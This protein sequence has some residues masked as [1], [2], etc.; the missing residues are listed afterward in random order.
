MMKNI[1]RLIPFLIIIFTIHVSVYAQNQKEVKRILF[2]GNSYT[3]VLNTPQLVSIISEDTDTKLLTK[4]ST[5]GGAFL[6][7]HWQ[8]ERGLETREII[9]NG[10]FDAVVIQENSMGTIIHPDTTKKYAALL[11]DLIKESGAKPYLYLTWAREKVPQY[12]DRISK[13]YKEIASENDAVLIPNGEAWRLALNLRPSFELFQD[14]G[15]HQSKFGALLNATVFTGALTGE[16]PEEL[17]ENYQI[18][19]SEGETVE[20][21]PGLDPLDLV[22]IQKVASEILSEYHLLRE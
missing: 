6:S 8:S 18:R 15:S 20:L 3:Y 10:N 13:I 14:D 22:F 5:V 1:K 17:P 11:C 7:Q 16:L 19:D 2:V 21:L 9:K 12:Q 4:K